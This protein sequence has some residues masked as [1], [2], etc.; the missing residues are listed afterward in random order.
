MKTDSFKASAVFG[1]GDNSVSVSLYTGKPI[2]CADAV[3]VSM[4]TAAKVNY[5]LAKDCHF[6]VYSKDNPNI[7]FGEGDDYVVTDENQ[8]YHLIAFLDIKGDV[9]KNE[10]DIVTKLP[11]GLGMRKQAEMPEHTIFCF[12]GLNVML[13]EENPQFN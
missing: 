4:H 8:D 7:S 9:L 3:E 12:S 13:F 11:K 10:I 2:K 1:L 5:F 6:L